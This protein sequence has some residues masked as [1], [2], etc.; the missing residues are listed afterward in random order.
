MNLADN[1]RGEPVYKTWETVLQ[2]WN[3]LARYAQGGFDGTYD[4]GTD[5]AIIYH[6]A[7]LF[8]P[9]SAVRE[10]ELHLTQNVGPIGDQLVAM[11]RAKFL[12]GGILPAAARAQLLYAGQR[13]MEEVKDV[14]DHIFETYAGRA[15]RGGVD[16]ADVVPKLP[17]PKPMDY[18][19]VV[20]RGKQTETTARQPP[21]EPPVIQPR[22][23]RSATDRLLQGGP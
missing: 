20:E 4:N 21:S 14:A 18:R 15:Q 11:Y 1:L 7:K 22:P 16:P 2:A 12:D 17:A 10:G 23:D 19:A 9:D 3:T 6:I 13:K 8:D 5:L